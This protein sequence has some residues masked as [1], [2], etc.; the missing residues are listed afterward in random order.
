[1]K[2]Q[3]EYDDRQP[4][5]GARVE[6]AEVLGGLRRMTRAFVVDD[7]RNSATRVA[8]QPEGRTIGGRKP[9]VRLRGRDKLVRVL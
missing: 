3:C 9:A 8:I 6:F 1:M 2:S 7:P 4:P 5:I